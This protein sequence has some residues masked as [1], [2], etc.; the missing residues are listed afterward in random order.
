MVDRVYKANIPALRRSL[1]R[2]KSEFSRLKTRTDWTK[3]RIDPL[4]QHAKQLERQLRAQGS[5]RLARGVSM[6]HSD[7]VYLQENVQG[8]KRVLQSE[9]KSLAGKI[10]PARKRAR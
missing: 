7:L 1:E 4:L 6:F 5:S 3:L 8:L 10:K 2:L 9:T